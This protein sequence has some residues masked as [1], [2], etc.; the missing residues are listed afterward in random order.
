MSDEKLSVCGL[1]VRVTEAL[2]PEAVMLAT[3]PIAWV[4]LREVRAALADAEAR[5]A[6]LEGVADAAREV[7][8]LSRRGLHSRPAWD[9][10]YEALL[11]LDR[12]TLTD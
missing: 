3:G 1:P 8:Y 7:S 4:E 10:L 12:V 2:P 5:V 6:A 11:A 9:A